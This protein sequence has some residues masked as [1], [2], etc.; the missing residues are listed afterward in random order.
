M[1]F[2]T[3][4]AAHEAIF[5]LNVSYAHGG[6]VS[7]TNAAGTVV[8]TYSYDPW[9]KVLSASE[10]VVNRYR[11]AGYR[12]DEGTGLY[13]L[14]HRYYSPGI[15]RFLTKDREKGTV[16]QPASL[17]AY[18]YAYANPLTF[19]DWTGK[20]PTYPSAGKG[21][22]YV[23]H[24]VSVGPRVY[25]TMRNYTDDVL[26]SVAKY[27]GI[28][29]GPALW[30][31]PFGAST[32]GGTGHVAPNTWY[33]QGG[34]GYGGMVAISV[35]IAHPFSSLAIE[36]GATWP[37]TSV[38]LFR[39]GDYEYYAYAA[40]NVAGTVLCHVIS[41]REPEPMIAPPDHPKKKA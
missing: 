37:N 23:A 1:S 39:T 41:P 5:S 36:G 20:A 18:L 27:D 2:P 25:G 31:L 17:N 3:L 16:V 6:V 15:K 12:Y 9:G 7:L 13:H 11:Y 29:G 21:D 26:V 19:V 8:N 35:E 28:S 34:G 14:W 30:K 10:Q 32:S 24:M 38:V 4:D 22:Y 33:V 40:H